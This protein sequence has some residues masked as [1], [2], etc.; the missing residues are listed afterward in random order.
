MFATGSSITLGTLEYNSNT[1]GQTNAFSMFL[2]NLGDIVWGYTI[3]SVPLS[4]VIF[5]ADAPLIGKDGYLYSFVNQY[6]ANTLFL[7]K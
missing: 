2:N 3:T 7:M 4:G 6:N 5:V 1:N